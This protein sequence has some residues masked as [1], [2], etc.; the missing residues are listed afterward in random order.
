MFD[1]NYMYCVFYS[2][3]QRDV[4]NQHIFQRRLYDFPHLTGFNHRLSS[5]EVYYWKLNAEWHSV[6]LYP[7]S[8]SLSLKIIDF[9][10]EC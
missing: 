8:T 10:L 2:I 1:C 3:T 9:L 7:N 4:L 5:I 6:S